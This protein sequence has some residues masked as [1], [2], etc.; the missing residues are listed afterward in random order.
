M[1]KSSLAAIQ[2]SADTINPNRLGTL[3]ESNLFTLGS[4]LEI[5]YSNN[6]EPMTSIPEVIGVVVQTSEGK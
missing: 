1:Q 2:S 3:R 4:M 5:S 6:A